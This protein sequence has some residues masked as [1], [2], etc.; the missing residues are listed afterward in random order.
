MFRGPPL[1]P[2]LSLHI[3]AFVSVAMKSHGPLPPKPRQYKVFFLAWEL[4]SFEGSFPKPAIFSV[5]SA[6]GGFI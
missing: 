3:D 2:Q 5:S 1:L 6:T 4:I